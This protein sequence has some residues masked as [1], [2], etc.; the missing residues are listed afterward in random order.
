MFIIRETEPGLW[1]IGA[2]SPEWEPHRDCDN[3]EEA[4]RLC[5]QLNGADIIDFPIEVRELIMDIVFPRRGTEAED[6]IIDPR[7]VTR[8]EAIISKYKLM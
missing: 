5:A 3:Q 4:E 6:Y 1:T 8:A 2:M 7:L